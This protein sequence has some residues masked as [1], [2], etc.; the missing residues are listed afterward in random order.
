M[1]AYRSPF[2]KGRRLRHLFLAAAVVGL[3]GGAVLGVLL[4]GGQQPLAVQLT[5]LA[6]LVAAALFEVRGGLTAA[7]AASLF[8]LLLPDHAF[9]TPFGVTA[10]AWSYQSAFFLLFAGTA[11]YV[12]RVFRRQVVDAEGV[13]DH[14]S[15][16]CV[17]LLSNLAL[18]VEG[19]DRGARGHCNR[20]AHNAGAMGGALGLSGKQ[21]ETLHWGALLH[22][23]G[24]IAVSE[25]ILLKPGALTEEEFSEIKRHSTY[26]AELLEAVSAE[27]M[28]IARVVHCH[29]ER[30][31]G[32]GYPLGL[33]QEAIPLMSRI[34][35][36]ADVFE[37]LTSERPYRKPMRPAQALAYLR[38]EAGSHFDPELVG[39]FED[40]FYQN[41]LQLAESALDDERAATHDP[42]PRV[43]LGL[44]EWQ[45]GQGG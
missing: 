3:L 12:V 15:E 17:S 14:L 25:K 6:V 33:G 19:R 7:A 27:F 23:L 30:W 10:W 8:L 18:I 38:A 41:Q 45:L 24:K 9:A 13:V 42:G 28:D 29:H 2:S 22:D 20:V 36:V 5:Y 31:D 44:S 26:G 4:F 16:V 40:L 43:A 37:A 32:L 39:L 11:G 1:Q 35:T 21:L 34:I